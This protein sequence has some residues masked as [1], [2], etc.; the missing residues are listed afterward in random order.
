M[1]RTVLVKLKGYTLMFICNIIINISHCG[2][3]SLNVHICGRHNTH[4]ALAATANSASKY[5]I[6]RR[7]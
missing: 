6:D 1:N 4:D 7:Y 2:V 3:E 5:S